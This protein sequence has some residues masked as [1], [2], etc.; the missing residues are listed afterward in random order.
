VLLL[1][2]ASIRLKEDA[3]ARAG[4]VAPVTSVKGGS[5]IVRRH[6]YFD[7]LWHWVNFFALGFVILTGMQIYFGWP[8][9][10]EYA[11]VRGI[12][13]T[14]AIFVALWNFPVFLYYSAVSGELPYFLFRF[15][16]LRRALYDFKAFLGIA[17]EAEHNTY[18]LE[19]GRYFRK[20][21]AMHKM[22]VWVSLILLLG[23]GT[24]GLSLW[25]DYYAF[26]SGWVGNI[27]VVRAVHLSLFYIFLFF[28]VGHIYFASVPWNWRTMTK[29][30]FNGV[31]VAKLHVKVGKESEEDRF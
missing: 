22:H 21:N 14:L 27:A 10:A 4:A 6:S 31:A 3:P 19:D 9:L 7:V 28:N 13:F 24:T 2:S 30:I 29:S 26:L 17:E 23:L 5:V 25:S 1:S 15:V 20:Y 16:D 11:V 18:D 8:F 12:H